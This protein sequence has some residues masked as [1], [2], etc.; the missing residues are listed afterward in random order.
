MSQKNLIILVAIIL[1]IVVVMGIY[2][3]VSISQK[4]IGTPIVGLS[5]QPVAPGSVVTNKPIVPLTP[6]QQLA[7]TKKD[8]PLVITGVI[9]FLDAK[10]YVNI[11]SLK[12]TIKTDDGKVY[13]LWPA[14]PESIYKYLGAQ[15]GGRVELQAKTPQN[16]EL[17]WGSMKPI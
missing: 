2:Y 14:Q 4:S 12:T 3:F 13:I 15:D 5:V 17:E 1:A 9:N 11:N 7:Q 16:G 10:V 8:Y 6:Q